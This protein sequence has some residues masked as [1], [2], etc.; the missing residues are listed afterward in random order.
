MS[1]QVIYLADNEA[2]TEF[3]GAALANALPKRALVA[4][5]GPLGAG[6]TRLVKA[7]AA[8]TG[9]RDAITSPT[10]VLV[11]EYVGK[12]PIYHFDAYRLRDEDEFSALGPEEYFA[13][14]GWCFIEW[15]DRVAACLP[16]ERLEIL[17]EPTGEIS[18]R[19]AIYG[20]GGEYE[21]TLATL[22]DSLGRSA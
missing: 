13:R 8:A 20:Q 17:I 22:R 18:R 6:K 21:S 9:V 5:V 3:L 19:F 10:F 2:A 4:L 14:D 7:V 1:E 11:H 16:R 15:A 12:R